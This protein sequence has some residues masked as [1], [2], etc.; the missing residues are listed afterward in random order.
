MHI[1]SFFLAMKEKMTDVTPPKLLVHTTKKKSPHTVETKPR[2]AKLECLDL[3]NTDTGTISGSQNMASASSFLCEKIP[4]AFSTVNQPL[5]G[6]RTNDAIK[7][8]ITGTSTARM[9]FRQL[10]SL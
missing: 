2:A 4:A 6:I 10:P 7:G 8:G 9:S 1:P 5:G 3:R